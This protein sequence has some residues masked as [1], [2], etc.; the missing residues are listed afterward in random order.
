MELMTDVAVVI[1][2][3]VAVLT[4]FKENLVKY[5]GRTSREYTVI[6]FLIL[7]EFQVSG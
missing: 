1:T 3:L 6:L 5:K 4:V 7:S 2:A